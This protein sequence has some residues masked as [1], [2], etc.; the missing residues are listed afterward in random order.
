MLPII[1]AS[2][3]PAGM[4]PQ[5]TMQAQMVALPGVSPEAAAILSMIPI[6]FSLAGVSPPAGHA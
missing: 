5:V 1:F 3:S 4:S 2:V 6:I